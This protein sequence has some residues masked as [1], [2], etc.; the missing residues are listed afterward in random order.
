MAPLLPPS[1]WVRTR[2]R[3]T[4]PGGD[5]ATEPKEEGRVGGR[6][7]GTALHITQTPEADLLGARTLMSDSQIGD[8]TQ[9]HLNRGQQES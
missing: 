4:L 8:E 9:I 6:R 5:T 2:L 1:L 3:W 7:G